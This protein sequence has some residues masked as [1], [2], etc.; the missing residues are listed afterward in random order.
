MKA[1]RERQSSQRLR[2]GKCERGKQSEGDQRRKTIPPSGINVTMK[3]QMLKEEGVEFD[4]WGMLI[5][6]EKVLWDGPWKVRKDWKKGR[7]RRLQGK[8]A[9]MKS[10]ALS[11]IRV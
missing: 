4:E 9:N 5:D 11:L 6:G 1:H 3:L 2:A 8:Q 7:A 10:G